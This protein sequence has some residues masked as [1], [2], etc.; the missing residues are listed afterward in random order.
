[1]QGAN[2]TDA[3]A[4]ARYIDNVENPQ[5][6]GEVII[7]RPEYGPVLPSGGLDAAAS[8][9]GDVATVF[10]Q[11]GGDGRRLVAGLYDTPPSRIAGSNSQSIRRL[12]RLSWAPSLNLFGPVTYRVFVDGRQIAETTQSQVPIA[13]K[14]IPDGNHT[15]QI[16]LRDRRGQEVRSRTRRLRVDN[17]PPLLSVSLSRR[18]RV[19][20]I[21]SRARDSR[22]R[23]KS[24]M[25]RILVDWGD[26]R[27]VRA[28][29]RASKRYSRGGRYTVRIKAVDRAGNETLATRRVQ[30][31]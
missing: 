2:A 3:T 8:R 25:G 4:R 1:M 12:T 26:K 14:Q 11:A 9:R 28:G 27:L 30:I 21:G 17:T 15:W 24:G 23:L 7:S 22:G 31:G 16:I 20:S 10:V 18:G 5:L 6:Q 29:T 19:L 13:P